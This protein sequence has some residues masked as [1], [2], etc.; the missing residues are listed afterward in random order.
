MRGISIWWGDCV[1]SLPIYREKNHCQLT[2]V[3][4][5]VLSW[6]ADLW[7][8]GKITCLMKFRLLNGLIYSPLWRVKICQY[9][10]PFLQMSKWHGL[11]VEKSKS[12]HPLCSTC[13]CLVKPYWISSVATFASFHPALDN[14][15]C[16]VCILQHHCRL[17]TNLWR[18]KKSTPLALLALPELLS[19]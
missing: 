5:T 8:C 11:S 10:M 9:N 6:I 14:R 13:T 17:L 16:L 7:Y 1:K 19:W 15:W 18:G 3:W 2:K 12:I 4:S